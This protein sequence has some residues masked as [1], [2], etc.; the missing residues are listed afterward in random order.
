VSGPPSLQT[1]RRAVQRG[2]QETSD[3]GRIHRE[4]RDD[5]V[6]W[7]FLPAVLDIN[8]GFSSDVS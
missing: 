4:A 2:D 8:A 5:T 3:A 1:R 6:V 7:S